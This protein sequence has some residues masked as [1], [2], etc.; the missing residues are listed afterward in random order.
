LF[1]KLFK[2][3]KLLMHLKNLGKNF[4]K[5]FKLKKIIHRKNSGAI[6]QSA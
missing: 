4:L 2:N 6:P 1:S 5:D 3:L